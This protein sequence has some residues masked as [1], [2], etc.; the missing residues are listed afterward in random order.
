MSYSVMAI[1]EGKL[2][3]SKAI[4]MLGGMFD[5]VHF[6]HLRTMLD[7]KQKLALHRLRVVPCA[8]PP[9]R[10]SA[11]VSAQ[12]RVDMLRLALSGE[13]GIEI[14]EQEI[15][16]ATPSYS[17][18]T[19][20]SLREELGEQ[21]I[22]LIIGMDAFKGLTT[23]YRWQELIKL[24]H[25]V[26]M[27][28]PGWQVDDNAA[29]Q[30]FIEQHRADDVAMIHGRVAGCVYFCPVTGLDISSTKI[31]AY[32]QQGLSVRYL[33]PEEVREYIERNGLYIS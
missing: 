14:D 30:Q 32:L 23:W 6:G 13:Q 15:H 7:V 28:R 17:Y 26:V 5:P 24:C 10:A 9:H 33:L 27:T 19:L 20:V 8:I 12:Q 2:I 16:R 31:R 3:S 29:L 18:D 21:P 1:S 4:G 11:Q 22:C 25:I